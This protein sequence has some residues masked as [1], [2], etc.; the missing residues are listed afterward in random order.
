[1]T[2]SST[3]NQPPPALDTVGRIARRLGVPVHRVQYVVDRKAIPPSAYAGRLRLYSREAVSR[4]RYE[5]TAIDAK[6][7]GV[8]RAD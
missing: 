3:I 8:H 6:R 4:I 5:L 2:S 7:E 1:M